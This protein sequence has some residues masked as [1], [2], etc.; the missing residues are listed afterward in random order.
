MLKYSDGFTLVSNS[1]GSKE[2]I[3]VF[4]PEKSILPKLGAEMSDAKASNSNQQQRQK[5]SSREKKVEIVQSQTSK[6][7]DD[8]IFN[9][10]KFAV[11]TVYYL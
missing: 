6:F 4:H 7:A 1:H 3:R 5:S 11:F 9:E 10:T 8:L 2:S